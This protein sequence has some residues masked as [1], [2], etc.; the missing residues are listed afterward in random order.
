MRSL[1]FAAMLAVVLAA[2]FVMRQDASR[3]VAQDAKSAEEIPASSL[4]DSA[5]G[6]LAAN[7]RQPFLGPRSCAAV[8]CH[9]RVSPNDR[10]PLSRRNEYVY[11]LD[12]DPHARAYQTLETPASLTMMRRL[13]IIDDKEEVL[14]SEAL[15]NCYGCHNPQPAAAQQSL[16]FFERDGVSCEICHGP[17]ADWIG[18]HVSPGWAAAKASGA[19]AKLGFIDT[20][21]VN[22]RA[23]TCAQCHVGSPGREVNHDLIAAGHP[24]LKFEFTAYH[25]LLPKHWRDGAERKRKPDFELHLWV[26]GQVASAEAALQLLRWRADRAERAAEDPTVAAVWPEFAEYDCFA[27][28]HDLVYP[29]RRQQQSAGARP[30]GMASWGGWYFGMA[31]QSRAAS[32]AP[33]T[34]VMQSG[35]APQPADVQA[36]ASALSIKSKPL[37]QWIRSLSLPSDPPPIDWDEATQLYL[38]LV[39]VEQSQRDTGQQPK[40]DVTE[41]IEKLRGQLAFPLGFE[42]P[43][44]LFKPGHD[45]SR[46]SIRVSFEEFFNK[47][48][49]R[50]EL[51]RE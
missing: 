8:A 47:F 24:V 23:E 27:C 31:K 16:T 4:A 50:S 33:L 38:A 22:V 41:A 37:D 28:H 42:S 45:K 20:E 18:R 14:D 44:D 26:A 5:S 40:A 13:N 35:F 39:A 32:F 43:K 10:F 30:P 36:A 19:A 9:G 51:K 21:D 15:A 2:P 12:K 46:D 11:W 29:S 1:S 48:Q 6:L 49:R 7:Q 3:A 34:T 25:D 17:S